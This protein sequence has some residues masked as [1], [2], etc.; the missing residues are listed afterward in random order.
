M[1]IFRLLNSIVYYKKQKYCNIKVNIKNQEIAN[2]SSAQGVN[3][4]WTMINYRAMDN[5]TGSFVVYD[6]IKSALKYSFFE[7]A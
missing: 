4:V 1:K 6:A 3:A 2:T 5:T 7:Y